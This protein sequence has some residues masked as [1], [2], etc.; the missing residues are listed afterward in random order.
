M[1]RLAEKGDRGG[2]VEGGGQGWGAGGD[3]GQ[4]DMGVYQAWCQVLAMG[5]NSDSAIGNEWVGAGGDVGDGEDF[6]VRYV[7]I[8][9]GEDGAA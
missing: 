1:A 7:H 5:G 8:A 3:G 4:V 2:N 9:V 6:A